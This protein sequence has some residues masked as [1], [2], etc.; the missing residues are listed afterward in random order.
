MRHFKKFKDTQL[1]IKN[2]NFDEKKTYVKNRF[3]IKL[4]VLKTN[5]YRVEIDCYCVSLKDFFMHV[6]KEKDSSKKA[7]KEQKEELDKILEY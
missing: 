7:I 1:M 4:L 5:I 2:F 6:V 3:K